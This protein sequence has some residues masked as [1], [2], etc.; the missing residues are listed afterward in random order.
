MSRVTATQ[1][2][3]GYLTSCLIVPAVILFASEGTALRK[4]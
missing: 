1:V 3:V 2:T 4:N